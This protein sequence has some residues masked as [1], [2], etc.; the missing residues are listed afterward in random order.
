MTKQRIAL[1]NTSILTNVTGGC[2]ADIRRSMADYRDH[3]HIV[4]HKDCLDG[5]VAGF[6]AWLLSKN[7]NPEAIPMSYQDSVP[8]MFLKSTI[9]R[10]ILFVDFC[11]APDILEA[12]AMMGH[13]VIVIDHHKSAIDKIMEYPKEITNFWYFVSHENLAMTY[14]QQHSGASLTHAFFNY[15]D[16]KPLDDRP[17]E[18]L[19]HLIT[20]AREHDLWL[21]RGDH[22]TDAMAL[23]YW[24]KDKTVASLITY[25]L[26]DEFSVEAVES[27]VAEGRVHLDKAVSEINEVIKCGCLAEIGGS[28]AWLF[29]CERAYTSLA[30]S[31]VNQSYDIAVSFYRDGDKFKM[32]IR[33]ADG[34]F[35]DASKLAGIYGGGGHKHAAG[36]Y[37]DV[38]PAVLLKRSA[39]EPY[40]QG[41]SLV[42]PHYALNP[43]K[44]GP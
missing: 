8:D 15:L 35:A 9:K 25:W 37:T 10:T 36:F 43:I 21:H 40:M 7:C 17:D 6:T 29:Y 41:G 12:M 24:H 18:G 26:A 3:T 23:A 31:I 42:V 39:E 2:K 19:D 4:Y 34:S 1:P 16:N 38:Y 22:R 5:T 44:E 27:M 13:T 11:V 33:T 32:S 14:D 28:R 30:G 20:L